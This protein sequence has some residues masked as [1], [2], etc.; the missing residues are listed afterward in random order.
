[1][2]L[3]RTLVLLSVIPVMAFGQRGGGGHGGGGGGMRGGG[4]GGMRGGGGGGM[5]GGGGGMRGGGGFRGGGAVMRGGGGFRGGNVVVR[6]GGFRGNRFVGNRFNNGRFFNNRR[7]F[8]NGRFFNSGF[9]F[10]GF[11]GGFGDYGYPYYYPY[12]YPYYDTS[13]YDSGY[14]DPGYYDPGYYAAPYD[15]YA[16]YAAAGQ[17]AVVNQVIPVPAAQAESY[18]RAPDYYLIAFNDHTI[19]AAVS[20]NVEGNQLR[21]VT[22][23]HEVRTAPLMNVDVQFSQQINRDRHVDFRLPSSQ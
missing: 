12:S 18:Y 21:Y 4:G 2:K 16:G 19:Q 6:N 20:F 1:M 10:P 15:G 11:Y 8:N 23:Q 9:F 5:R 22:R 13:Y 7:F 14:Y 17:P 3:L